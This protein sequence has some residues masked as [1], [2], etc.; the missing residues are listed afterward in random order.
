MKHRI[1]EEFKLDLWKMINMYLPEPP[2][3][4]F[5]IEEFAGL[6]L[7]GVDELHLSGGEAH[8]QRHALRRRRQVIEVVA[9]G[10]RSLVDP[11]IY[12]LTQISSLQRTTERD[13][14]LQRPHAH[15][16]SLSHTHTDTRTQRD[17]N[18]HTHREKQRH[19]HT[20]T[21]SLMHAHA[22]RDTLHTHTER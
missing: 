11:L 17:T 7:D 6:L 4:H 9:R 15:T 14:H 10:L 13:E 18:T 21:H 3:T 20:H 2:H 16:L 22:E 5:F 8:Q 12:R 1:W 19:T